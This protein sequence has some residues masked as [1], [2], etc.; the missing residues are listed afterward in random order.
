MSRRILICGLPGAGKTTLAEAL[1]PLLKAFHINADKVRNFYNDWD[2]SPEGRKRQAG[3][4]KEASIVHGLANRVTVTDFVAP[5]QSI[6]DFFD[7][8]FVIW[9][10]TINESRFED[11]N[12]IFEPVTK[13]DV[14]IDHYLTEAE[15]L[16]LVEQIKQKMEL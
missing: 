6:R 9:V 5:T 16:Q 8:D 12:A 10:N 13:C 15:L 11:T 3:R 7:A 2:F 1:T 4:M 14:V